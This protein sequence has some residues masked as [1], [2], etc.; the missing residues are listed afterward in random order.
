M[1]ILEF[2]SVDKTFRHDLDG[3]HW[4]RIYEYPLVLDLLD[5]YGAIKDSHVHN[6]FGDGKEFTFGLKIF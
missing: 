5:K 3:V 4:S 2:S 1:K 6:T